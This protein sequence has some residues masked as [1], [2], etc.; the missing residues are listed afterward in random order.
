[1]KPLFVLAFIFT[2]ASLQAQD[3][4]TGLPGDN[5]SLAGAL[6]LFKQAGSPEA[7]EKLLN[8]EDSK[9]NNLDLNGDG[10]TD[11]IRVIN[12]R[13][14][15]VQVFIL[16]ALV[17]ESESQDIA[18]IELEKTGSE[19]AIVQI[20]GDEDIYGEEVI[21][22]PGDEEGRAYH[23]SNMRGP[24]AFDTEYFDSGAGIVVNVWAWPVVRFVFAP[25]YVVWVSPF[26]WT[27]RPVW[28]R[29]WRP[30]AWHVYRPV[31][32]GWH[33]HYTVV[34]THR[35]VHA[36]TIYR[37]VRVSS[38]TVRTRNQVAVNNYRVSRSTH[39]RTVTTSQGKKYQVTKRNT[40]VHGRHGG[41]ASRSTT[42]VRRKR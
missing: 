15:N 24:A 5:F 36:R 10:N 18:V 6:E 22:E 21:V 29:P 13:D 26:R 12:K 16:Q 17:S 41:H 30:L 38:V 23:K 33:R 9:V 28:Y 4:G 11:Y 14:N 31:H 42:T 20:T 35:I 25:S 34:H 27:Y 7:F 19:N 32:Y 39:T 37:P 40:T 3:D 8:T 2:T 1:M